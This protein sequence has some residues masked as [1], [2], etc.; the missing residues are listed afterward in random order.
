M[1]AKA[2]DKRYAIKYSK[3]KKGGCF[4]RAL[5]VDSTYSKSSLNIFL[6]FS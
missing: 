5:L 1:K 4:V 2:G 6:V 3:Y